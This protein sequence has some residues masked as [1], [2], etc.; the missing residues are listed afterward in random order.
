MDWG[1][2]HTCGI[3]YSPMSQGVIERTHHTLKSILDKQKGGVTQ[4]TPPMQ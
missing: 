4:A 3:R 2:S 1:V